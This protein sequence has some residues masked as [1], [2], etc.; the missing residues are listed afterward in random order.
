MSEHKEFLPPSPS[1]PRSLTEENLEKHQLHLDTTDLPTPP[2]PPAIKKNI[3]P[4]TF[5]EHKAEVFEVSQRLLDEVRDSEKLIME[6]HESLK[7]ETNNSKNTVLQDMTNLANLVALL[8]SQD[9]RMKKYNLPVSHEAKLVLSRLLSVDGYFDNLEAIMKDIV[10]DNKI[11]A[12]DVPKIML[13]LTELYK[14]LQQ[15]KEVKFDERL[16][17]EILKTLFNIALKEQ[18]IPVA[19]QDIELLK[20]LYEIVDTS[21]TLMQTD[22]S[23]EK[24]GLF[25]HLKKCFNSCKK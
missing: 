17:G 16:C 7:E 4:A 18:L 12:R 21:I 24:K 9:E 19:E 2:T 20:C 23:G 8:L 3:T 10:H 25:Y 22:T 6:T 13:L 14:M 15:I 5:Q 11:D 1:S